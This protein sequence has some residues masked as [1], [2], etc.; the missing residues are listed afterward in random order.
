MGLK[1]EKVICSTPVYEVM[2]LQHALGANTL[3]EYCHTQSSGLYKTCNF[4][5]QTISWYDREGHLQHHGY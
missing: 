4:C 1:L 2:S 5:L 3:P